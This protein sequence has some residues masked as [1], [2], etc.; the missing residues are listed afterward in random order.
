M[1]DELGAGL[2]PV[3]RE[4]LRRLIDFR[5]DPLARPGGEHDAVAAPPTRPV[6]AGRPDGSREQRAHP[7]A[8]EPAT[9]RLHPASHRARVVPWGASPAEIV[10]QDVRLQAMDF[11][12]V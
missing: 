3:K 2:G 1:L 8:H 12:D 11:V 6:R 9:P 5:F 10:A 4:E 7:S